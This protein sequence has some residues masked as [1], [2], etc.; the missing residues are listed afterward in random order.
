MS[1][2]LA[3][4]WIVLMSHACVIGIVSKKTAHLNTDINKYITSNANKAIR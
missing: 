2:L 1:K 3:I 4:T